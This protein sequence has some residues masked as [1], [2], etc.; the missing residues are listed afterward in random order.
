MAR[1]F[2]VTAAIAL[3]GC[4]AAETPGDG[5]PK[6]LASA[7]TTPVSAKP[8]ET[9][10]PKAPTARDRLQGKWEIT[11]YQSDRGI[12]D[13][14]MPVMATLFSKLRLEFNGRSALARIEGSAAQELA[15][16]DVG[17]ENGDDFTL[18]APGFMFDGAK[19]RFAAEG[20]VEIK[21][22]GERWPGVSALKR[23]P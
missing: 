23:L 4:G 21:D 6:G 19:C 17:Y 7:P 20:V 5:T 3:S 11:R 9:A 18:F 10:A 2:T 14:A 1:A 16:F 13:E 22:T 12:P 15:S 8:A